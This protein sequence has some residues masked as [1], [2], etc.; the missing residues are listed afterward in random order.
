MADSIGK[1]IRELRVKA[2]LSQSQ[3][4]GLID[5]TRSAVSQYES[6]T[7]VPRMGVIEDMARVFHVPKSSIIGETGLKYTVVDLLEE[8]LTEHDRLINELVAT[9]ACLTAQQI[10]LLVMNASQFANAN[11]RSDAD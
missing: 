8:P 1:R 11:M 3:L 4:G 10:E 6:D 7:I 2:G 9:C 5:K